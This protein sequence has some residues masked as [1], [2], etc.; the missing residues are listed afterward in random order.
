MTY[1]PT[2]SHATLLTTLRR[3]RALPGATEVL[4]AE[5]QRVDAGDV[6]AR[7]EVTEAH[8]LVD[9]ST[10]LGVKPDKLEP[11][12]LKRE[13]D[14]VKKGDAIAKRKG[15]LGFA[16]SATANSD[17]RLVLLDGGKALLAT[18]RPVEL[19]AG[20]PG[21]VVGRVTDGVRIEATG[22]LLSGVW[23][24]GQE[25]FSVLR[26]LTS[27]PDL[28]LH[29]AL[30]EPSLRGAIVAGGTLLDPS[31][32]DGLAEVGVGGLI[33]GRLSTRFLA[34]A[35]K[36][37][38]PV[39]IVEGFGEGGFSQ[40]V[41]ALLNGNSG[42]EVWLNACAWDRGAAQ[43]PEAIIPL[44]ANNAPTL[45]PGEP[46]VEGKRVRILRGP[47]A[48]RVGHVTGLSDRP[49]LLPSG[50]RARLAVIA[51]DD[52]PG[53]RPTVSAPFANLEILA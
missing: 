12:L 31:L 40:P 34:A 37:A 4:V 26:V 14:L 18:V 52:R 41:F 35:T 2:T 38:F 21:T 16:R 25:G 9:L 32:F 50:I 13:G 33:L 51:L 43:R 53:Q 10:R 19:R 24:N 48:G 22:A 47:E 15:F 1:L 30:I 6:I 8:Q 3:Q 5:G 42:R 27:E 44:P 17:S 45:A 49:L 7:G 36:A 11:F 46:L 23:G 29:G 39:L 20:L 28:A